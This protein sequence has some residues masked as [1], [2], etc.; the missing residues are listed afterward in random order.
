MRSA[1]L[2]RVTKERPKP[3]GFGLI[4][5]LVTYDRSLVACISSRITTVIQVEKKSKKQRLL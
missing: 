3:E 1:V 4:N 2:F 5:A